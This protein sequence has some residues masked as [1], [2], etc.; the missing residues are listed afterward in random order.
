MGAAPRGRPGWPDLA[1]STASRDSVRTVFTQ[2][3][4]TSS[5]GR[6]TRTLLQ[7]SRKTAG[8]ETLSPAPA[9]SETGYRR[10]DHLD[11]LFP[12]GSLCMPLRAGV[13]LGGTK[14]QTVVTD[15]QHSVLGQARHP[16]PKDDGPQ[17]V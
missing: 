1:F 2:S 5:N 12:E 4:S 17:G 6:D 13:D 9:R 16:T 3:W 7:R 14:I 10:A 15:D 8:R 11:W